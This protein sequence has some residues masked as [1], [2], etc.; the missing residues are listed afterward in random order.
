MISRRYT[1]IIHGLSWSTDPHGRA[2]WGANMLTF[3]VNGTEQTTAVLTLAFSLPKPYLHVA[4]AMIL[5][6]AELHAHAETLN[7]DGFHSNMY[8]INTLA[9]SFSYC[10]NTEWVSRLANLHCAY[11]G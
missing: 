11:C 10:S 7:C 4:M 3:V 5:S 2:Q 6:P 1:L 8:A 9:V